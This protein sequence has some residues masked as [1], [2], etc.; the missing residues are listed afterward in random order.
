MRWRRK[1]DDAA[2][3]LRAVGKQE[4]FRWLRRLDHA[5]LERLAENVR[6]DL[7]ACPTRDDL[8][9]AAARLHYQ[10]RP[11]IEGRLARGEDVVDEEAARGR[12]LAVIFER[13]YGVSLE[14]ALDEGLPVDPA[15]EEAHLRVERVLRQLGLAY[16]VLDE[17]HWVFELESASVHIRHYVASGSLD[18]YAP[19]RAWEEDGDEAAEALLRQN[20]GSV[21]GAFWG[22]CTFETAGDH[23]CACARLATAELGPAAVSFA[24]ASVA[25]LVEAAQRAGDGD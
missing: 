19:V 25:Q 9:E 5:E 11:R 2:A 8:L 20:G 3:A 1:R 7:V 23:L 14:L 18:V 16:T 24:L 4:P 13:R 17:G 21:A 6:G 22:V 10:T 15:V 12:A